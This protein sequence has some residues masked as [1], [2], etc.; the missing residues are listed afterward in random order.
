V[1]LG[2]K[3]DS[4]RDNDSELWFEGIL[5]E[6]HHDKLRQVCLEKVKVNKK[7]TLRVR[8]PIQRWPRVPG[9]MQSA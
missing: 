1:T 9:G 5:V 8:R 7:S 6:A 2:S 4:H 3:G